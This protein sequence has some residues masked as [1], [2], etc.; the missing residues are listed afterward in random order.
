MKN[1]GYKAS[2]PFCREILP[3]W[4]LSAWVCGVEVWCTKRFL[5]LC[6]ASPDLRWSVHSISWWR[7]LW[8]SLRVR[9]HSRDETSANIDRGRD[10]GEIQNK[11]HL[12]LMQQVSP[13]SLPNFR[14]MSLR[15]AEISVVPWNKR[16][17]NLVQLKSL[18][19]V[20]KSRLWP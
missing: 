10:T 17:Q 4:L 19:K 7:L 18:A 6:V 5:S 1:L 20:M 9:S 16:D 13:S 14:I 8:L 11:T 2:L 12:P 15:A 3:S